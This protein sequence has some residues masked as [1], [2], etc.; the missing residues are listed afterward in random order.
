MAQIR[1]SANHPDVKVEWVVAATS[2]VIRLKRE[3]VSSNRTKTWTWW[4]YGLEIFVTLS[5]E[6]Y[7]EMPY[8][9]LY[10]NKKLN[11]VFK[12]RLPLCYICN[13]VGPLQKYGTKRRESREEAELETFRVQ[14]E[15][16]RENQ[17]KKRAGEAN[18]IKR[19][20]KRK[21]DLQVV[22]RWHSQK[23]W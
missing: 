1:T 10:M 5:E 20:K 11:I 15:T 22:K 19:E 7:R 23:K 18:S 17:N 2:K 16:K 8:V 3:I 14:R 12:G 9:L 21:V 6:D 13:K 4:S